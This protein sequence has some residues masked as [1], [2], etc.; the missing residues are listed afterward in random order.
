MSEYDNIPSEEWI[1][2][3]MINIPTP[4]PIRQP[5]VDWP[6][7]KAIGTGQKI[8][9]GDPRVTKL[10]VKWK[11]ERDPTSDRADNFLRDP[12]KVEEL[13]KALSISL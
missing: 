6:V 12:K 7:T 13:K 2:S 5:K 8:L 3:K 4:R 10:I 9:V 11:Q 1:D